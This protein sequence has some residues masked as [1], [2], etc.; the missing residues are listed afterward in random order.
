[1]FKKTLLA[2]V[3]V[4]FGAM[5][6]AAHAAQPNGYLFVSA[7]QSDAD[8]SKQE[9]D[10]FWGVTPGL[11]VSSSLDNKDTA[12]KIGAGIQLNPYVAIEFQYLDLGTAEY[13]AS[14]A[15]AEAKTTA[16]TDGLGINAV[17]TIGFDRLSLFGKVGYHQ[18]KTEVKN[19]STFLVNGSDSEK[20]NVMSLGLGAAF[21]LNESFS[22]VAEYERYQDVADE[23]DVDMLSAGM[24]YNF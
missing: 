1:M 9:L 18:L 24:R 15:F 10:N 16:Q 4:G 21:A 5:A 17:G 20:E 13:K 14:N 8:I 6:G 2:A 19:S 11:G 22:L 23:Y 7:G 12:F 3:V